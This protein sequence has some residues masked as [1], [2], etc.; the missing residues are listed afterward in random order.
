MLQ[1]VVLQDEKLNAYLFFFILA[2][3]LYTI[4]T[5]KNN[6]NKNKK[7]KTPRREKHIKLPK[8]RWASQER[9]PPPQS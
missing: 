7:K 1:N 3:Y 5:S 2:L 9:L 8:V 6:K 4:N